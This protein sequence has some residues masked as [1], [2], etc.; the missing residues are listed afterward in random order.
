MAKT[1]WP[2]VTPFG[3][4]TPALQELWW[5]TN[6]ATGHTHDGTDADGSVPKVDLTA[7]V[8]GVLPVANYGISG[9]VDVKIVDTFI[10]TEATATWSYTKVGNVVTLYI[11]EIKGLETGGNTELLVTPDT[12]WPAA[13]LNTGISRALV[14]VFSGTTLKSGWIG[15]PLTVGASDAVALAVLNAS[16]DFVLDGFSG[17][18]GLDDC[19]ITYIV[20]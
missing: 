18:K 5:G 12:V 13:I 1:Q 8:T 4:I 7:H 3:H 15:I 2:I 6:A 17:T 16:Q 11:R 10:D 9:T 14:P 19:Y 20:D